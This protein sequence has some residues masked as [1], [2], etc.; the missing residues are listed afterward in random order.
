MNEIHFFETSATKYPAT[1]RHIQGNRNPWQH[2]C[3]N[4]KIRTTHPKKKR[5]QLWFPGHQQNKRETVQKV[6]ISHQI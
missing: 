5:V 4:V 6:D 1:Q 2:R 3:E